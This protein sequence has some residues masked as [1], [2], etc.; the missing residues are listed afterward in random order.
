MNH[1]M[2]LVLG[3]IIGVNIGILISGVIKMGKT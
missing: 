1:W 3:I 2:Y